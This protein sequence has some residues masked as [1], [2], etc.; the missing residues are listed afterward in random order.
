MVSVQRTFSVDRSVHDVLDYLKDFGN[1]EEWDP[2]TVSCER[3][4]SA[5]PVAEGARWH[6]VSR[7]LGRTTELTYRLERME[8]DRLVFVGENDKARSTDDLTLRAGVDGTEI[9][10]R[11]EI[12]FHG[13]IR[14]ADPLLRLP[15]EKI[16]TDTVKTMT[17]AIEGRHRQGD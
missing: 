6:N 7:F 3:I 8:P 14:F 10:Y 4:G 16:A 15:L 13:P 9:T 12:Q 1:A 11:A 2:G 5:S 17:E